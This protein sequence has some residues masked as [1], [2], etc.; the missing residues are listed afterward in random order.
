[1]GFI[2]LILRA[3]Y[4]ISEKF[5]SAFN[6]ISEFKGRVWMIHHVG[7]GNDEFTISPQNLERFLISHKKNSIQICSIDNYDCFDIFTIDDVSDDFFFKGF[8]LFLKYEIP[9]T[10]FVCVELLDKKGYITREQ[11]VEMSK[12]PLCTIG[13]HGLTHSFYKLLNKNKRVRFL[14]DSK[15]ILENICGNPIDV[16]AFPYGSLYACGFFHKNLVS[17]F[18]K[19]GFSTIPTV[20][21][22]KSFC[23]SYFLPRLNMNNK[24]F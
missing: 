19:Y 9:F 2:D 18:Y 8:P 21:T 16:F 24:Q 4:K 14:R 17:Q 6:G 3:V 5:I 23:M 22:V 1:M 15:Q 11:L 20:V 12:S 7:D 10:L 13:S